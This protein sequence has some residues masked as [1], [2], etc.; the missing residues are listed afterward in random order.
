MHKRIRESF[1]PVVYRKCGAKWILWGRSK[2]H[3]TRGPLFEA[4]G[5]STSATTQLAAGWR[6]W[7]H[8]EGTFQLLAHLTAA[9]ISKPSPNIPHKGRN[10]PFFPHHTGCSFD[11]SPACPAKPPPHIS[12]SPSCR[13]I[14]TF[15][16]ASGPLC[17]ATTALLPTTASNN[18]VKQAKRSGT[19]AAS[20]ASSWVFCCCSSSS[21]SL[22]AL[23]ST[24]QMEET[25]RRLCQ[26]PVREQR[27]APLLA[28]FSH[29]PRCCA[30]YHPG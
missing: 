25:S 18:P 26:L 24:A 13:P 28:V 10:S 11:K 20:S 9:R 5:F 8:G 3:R 1:V 27:Y 7:L 12:P 14:T 2:C 19:R 29:R 15:P 21:S 17:S 23:L 30:A 4:Q 22:S 16:P 6:C